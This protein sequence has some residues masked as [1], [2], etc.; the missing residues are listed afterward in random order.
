MCE[1]LSWEQHTIETVLLKHCTGVFG[2]FPVDARNVQSPLCRGWVSLPCCPD[3]L[4]IR[5]VVN[6]LF[7]VLSAQI[8]YL[9]FVSIPNIE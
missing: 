3:L 6:L 2:V 9:V 5:H 1:C 8:Q 4:E 7:L